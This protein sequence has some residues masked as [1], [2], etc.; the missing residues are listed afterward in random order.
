MAGNEDLLGLDVGALRGSRMA[1]EAAEARGRTTISAAVAGAPTPT[2]VFYRAVFRSTV[3]PEPAAPAAAAGAAFHERPRERPR[4]RRRRPTRWAGS[5]RSSTCRCSS[6]TR[7]RP[8]R[9][10]LDVEVLEVEPGRAPTVLYDSD[11]HLGTPAAPEVGDRYAGRPHFRETVLAAG[12]RTWTVRTSALPDWTDGG[13]TPLRF[14]V[15]GLGT[16][17]SALV[18]LVVAAATRTRRL[19]QRLAERATGHLERQARELAAARDDAMA[20]A[21][22][23]S[24]FLAAVSHEIRTPLNGVLGTSQLLLDAGL[25]VEPAEQVRTIRSSAQALLAILND[26]LDVSRMEAGRLELVVEPF[27]LREAVEEVLDLLVLSAAEKGVELVLRW[28]PDVASTFV[29]D[30]LRWKQVVLNLTGNAVKFTERGHVLVDVR[31]AVTP[32]GPGVELRVEDTGIGIPKDR[33]AA[34]FR[35]FSQAD[36]SSSR[37]YGG[38][39]LGLV[40][41]RLLV[42]RMGG[43]VEVTSEASKGSTFRVVVPLARGASTVSR[44]TRAPSTAAVLVVDDAEVARQVAV[45]AVAAL[46]ATV[47]EAADAAGGP[48]RVAGRGRARPALRGRARRPRPARRRRPRPRTTVAG[49]SRHRGRAARPRRAGGPRPPRRGGPRGGLRRMDGQAPPGARPRRRARGARAGAPDARRAVPHPRR[50]R[51]RAS[52]PPRPR[53]AAAAPTAPDGATRRVLLVEDLDVNAP[54]GDQD[55]AA[56]RVHGGVGAR[57]HGGHRGR[58]ARRLRP[59]APRPPHAR[60]GR[61]RRRGRDPPAGGGRASRP[62]GRHDRRRDRRGPAPLRRGG[63]GRLRR[64]ARRSCTACRDVVERW[65]RKRVGPPGASLR[66][67]PSHPPRRSRRSRRLDRASL[68][69]VFAGDARDGARQARGHPTTE[70]HPHRRPPRATTTA[71]GQRASGLERAAPPREGAQRERSRGRG[72]PRHVRGPGG[73][74]AGDGEVGDDEG[75]AVRDE[76]VGGPRRVGERAADERDD[77]AHDEADGDEEVEH[78]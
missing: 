76:G 10:T 77:A 62:R 43:T 22:A 14:V 36:P 52:T 53:G 73:L 51:G 7:S 39:G 6:A 27:D 71:M 5:R 2:V 31:P 8:W 20:G 34:L 29:G 69:A 41:T 60:R 70:H 38:V 44:L 35:R 42:E 48:R 3:A 24:D 65:C 54:R 11:R 30:A 19:A 67:R 40:I 25:P 21:R 4:E 63:H 50:P 55:A 15:L 17:V 61:L 33:V 47:G 78:S 56:P 72:A 59:R 64:Q 32:T 26:I 49:R 23:K 9:P 68:G 13:T 16:V 1:L 45:E 75:D 74:H 58:R 18:F 66:R 28:A 46:G 12:G 57:R 37:R